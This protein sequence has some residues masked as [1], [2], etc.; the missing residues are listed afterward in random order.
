MV[1]ETGDDDAQRIRGADG[2]AVQ[3]DA[4]NSLCLI[5][6]TIIV[7]GTNTPNPNA[8]VIFNSRTQ[9]TAGSLSVDAPDAIYVGANQS[10]GDYITLQGRVLITADITLTAGAAAGSKHPAHAMTSCSQRPPCHGVANL[11]FTEAKRLGL[12]QSGRHVSVQ[13]VGHAAHGNARVGGA[14]RNDG[15]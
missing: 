10:A 12:G 6:K 5:A 3:V 15:V 13:I 8:D 7:G 1:S 9:A 2:A 14:G 4:A 11:A